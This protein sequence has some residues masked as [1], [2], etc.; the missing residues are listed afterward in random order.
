MPYGPTYVPGQSD[1]GIDR[2]LL[3]Y[4]I[5]SNIENQYEFVLKQWVNSAEFVGAVRM[6]PKCKDAIIGCNDPAESIFEIRQPD[7]PEPTKITASQISLLPRR[8][9]IVSSPA[10]R[11]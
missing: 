8:R 10:L 11:R 7:Q 3:G 5:C 9:P 2:G 6:N 4:F 1:D